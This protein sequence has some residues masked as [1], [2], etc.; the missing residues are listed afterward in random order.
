MKKNFLTQLV[1]L[2]C[3]F[4]AISVVTTSCVQKSISA[5]LSKMA[6]ADIRTESIDLYDS[7]ILNGSSV[8]THIRAD[9]PT[10]GCFLAVNSIQE[11][12]SEMLDGT[13]TGKL[14]DG[15]K[16]LKYYLQDKVDFCKEFFTEDMK[17]I[18]LS[19][20][21]DIRKIYETESLVTYAY[22]LETYLGGAH[23]SH[24]QEMQTFRKLD[25]RRMDWNIFQSNRLDDVRD[26]VSNALQKDFFEMNDKDYQELK[27][28]FMNGYFTLPQ[29]FPVFVEKGVMFLYQEYEIA[30][31]AAG[32]PQCVIPYAVLDSLLSSTG[33]ALLED[34]I[35]TITMNNE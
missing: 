5:S 6:P 21:V 2:F 9:Y 16:M 18:E 4:V 12:I 1:Y 34:D 31:Y 7:T 13:Y 23:G 11:W 22:T 28:G 15:E 26:L 10:G 32:S 3:F 25:G 33:K 24:F 19:Y 29:A 8:S 27:D 30:P 17:G 35:K 20:N 14:S